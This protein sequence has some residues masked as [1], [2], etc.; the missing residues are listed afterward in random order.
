M[1]TSSDLQRELDQLRSDVIHYR[2]EIKDAYRRI[3]H[4]TDRVQELED[5]LRFTRDRGFNA[6]VI[7]KVL[8]DSSPILK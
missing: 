1:T 3:A 4:L 6:S 5:V 2:D 8:A 7:D